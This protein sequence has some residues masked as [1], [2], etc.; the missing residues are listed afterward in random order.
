MALSM[1]LG[2]TEWRSCKIVLIPEELA[3][4]TLAQWARLW[5][6]QRAQQFDLTTAEEL[7]LEE[8]GSRPDNWRPR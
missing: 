5:R 3:D 8:H 6:E 1:H 4:K 2:F 7:A